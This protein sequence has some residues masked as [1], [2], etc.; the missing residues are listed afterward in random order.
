MRNIPHLSLSRMARIYCQAHIQWPRRMHSLP[1]RPQALMLMDAF[2]SMPQVEGVV[3]VARTVQE[4]KAAKSILQTAQQALKKILAALGSRP[5]SLRVATDEA[6][7]IL[8]GL[9]KQTKIDLATLGKVVRNQD[10]ATRLAKYVDTHND[11][12]VQLIRRAGSQIGTKPEGFIDISEAVAHYGKHAKNTGTPY[13]GRPFQGLR[14]YVNAAREITE[15]PA[16]KRVLYYHEGNPNLPRLGYIV[17][18]NGRAF[19]VSVA[20]RG[21]IATFHVLDKGWAGVIEGPTF[22]K[23]FKVDPF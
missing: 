12:A 18:K 9:A 13:Q 19:L 5:K 23:M 1:L 8:Q 3:V 4:V 22:G 6:L 11:A 15:D 14:D 17:E 21:Y 10:D 16:A 2:S 20:E 7:P